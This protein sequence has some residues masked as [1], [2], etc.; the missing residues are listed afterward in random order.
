MSTIGSASPRV[1]PP[2]I[3]ADAFPSQSKACWSRQPTLPI[4]RLTRRLCVNCGG[5]VKSMY[6]RG[7]SAAV[8]TAMCI[9]SLMDLWLPSKKSGGEGSPSR[10]QTVQAMRKKCARESLFRIL[11]DEADQSGWDENF[12]DS[13]CLAEAYG[14]NV[15]TYFRYSSGM[16]LST[17]TILIKRIYS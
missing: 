1:A 15:G 4:V 8:W 11:L 3:F 16:L 10:Q 12:D 17:W 5:C 6:H 9:V 14:K 2:T 7:K 13:Y